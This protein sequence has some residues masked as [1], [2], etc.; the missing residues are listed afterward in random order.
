MSKIVPKFTMFIVQ[1]NFAKSLHFS[2]EIQKFRFRFEQ[3]AW[4][5]KIAD[6]DEWGLGPVVDDLNAQLT[7]LKK[8]VEDATEDLKT[9]Y[10]IVQ[11]MG[12]LPAASAKA[13]ENA[14]RQ[15]A[16]CKDKITR[17]RL[18]PLIRFDSFEGFAE[19]GNII[20][21]QLYIPSEAQQDVILTLST[22]VDDALDKMWTTL[23]PPRANFIHLFNLQP[24]EAQ[25][26][27]PF[28]NTLYK[29]ASLMWSFDLALT[30]SKIA[31]FELTVYSAFTD[32]IEKYEKAFESEL[33]VDEFHKIDAYL[34]ERLEPLVGQGRALTPEELRLIEKDGLAPEE[35]E[36]IDFSSKKIGECIESYTNIPATKDNPATFKCVPESQKQYMM[37]EAAKADATVQKFTG[38]LNTMRAKAVEVAQIQGPSSHPFPNDACVPTDYS[39]DVTQFFSIEEGGFESRAVKLTSYL[40]HEVKKNLDKYESQFPTVLAPMLHGRRKMIFQK[41]NILKAAHDDFEKIMEQYVSMYVLKYHVF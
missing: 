34:K 40:E 13:L 15:W 10:K 36:E 11:T 32:T 26:P 18:L 33:T 41:G 8:E 1:R 19:N 5:I 23:Q 17:D 30:A 27:A 21:A 29:E 39:T 25:P 7:D 37:I 31:W 4:T 20:A 38:A 6:L 14:D 24:A 35:R 12:E 28:Q 2:P 9:R 3:N 22:A 16:A